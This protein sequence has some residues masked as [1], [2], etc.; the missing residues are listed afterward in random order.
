MR[1]CM[2]HV[3]LVSLAAQLSEV[4]RCSTLDNK[5]TDGQM[6]RWTDTQGWMDGLTAKVC[7]YMYR[8]KCVCMYACIIISASAYTCMYSYVNVLIYIYVHMY[9]RV[10]MRIHM[11]MCVCVCGGGGRG[12]PTALELGTK[13]LIK[14]PALG[15]TD[16]MSSRI[17]QLRYGPRIGELL[18]P[19][20]TSSRQCFW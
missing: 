20:R 16:R 2:E 19:P 5:Q 14:L 10:Y 9:T 11:G 3:R 12:W 7:V 15:P 18:A 8:Y 1:L 6:N 17:E 4:F 13:M